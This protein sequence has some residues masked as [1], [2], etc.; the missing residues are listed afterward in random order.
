[1]KTISI[2]YKFDPKPYQLPVLKALQQGAKR[3]VICW[4]RR[5][6]KDKVC[7]NAM[8]KAMAEK[9]MQGS[10]G[11]YYYFTPT[12]T[13]GRKILWDAIDKSG[14]RF[15]DHFPSSFIS[16]VN[17]G[18]MKIWTKNGSLFQV[19]GTDRID[20]VVGSNP[21]GCV[22]GEYSLQNPKAWDYMRP[23]LAENNGWAIFNFTPRGT[24]HAHALLQQG[25]EAGWFTQTLTV[26]DTQAISEEAL[27]QEQ[28]Q[29]PPAL[30]EQE[31]N[32]KFINGANQYFRKIDENIYREKMVIDP[33]HRYV[34]GVDL[35]KYDDYTVLTPFNLHTFQAGIPDRFRQIDYPTQEARIE[36]MH[37][38]Y[39]KATVRV[40]QTGVGD[41]IYDYLD[42]KIRGV[43]GFKF[44]EQSRKDLLENLRL[45]LER[46]EIKIP[47]DETLISELRSVQYELVES[48]KLK[49]SV[50]YGTHDDCV[51]SLALATWDLPEKP[52]RMREEEKDKF[53]NL[54]QFDAY[55]NKPNGRYL[56]RFNMRRKE[57]VVM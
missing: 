34:I 54:F 47:D 21:V 3:A 50:P 39:N 5:A 19:V 46:E 1:M 40:D 24:N 22:F 33:K 57:N 48:G 16:K 29:M 7:L 32:C 12:Y 8:I 20:S 13:Q 14:M 2:P 36:A 30:F 4:H 56:A 42:K 53:E 45:K 11:I 31:Y 41:P 55:R 43:Q 49:I 51:I 38:Q 23:A 37:K 35:A 15:I 17:D 28:Q 26:E 18:E 52:L 27:E 25:K 9:E 10:K 6:G 44:T